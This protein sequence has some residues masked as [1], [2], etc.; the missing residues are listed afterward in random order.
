MELNSQLRNL[1]L[2]KKYT[3]EEVATSIEI[4]QA[5]LSLVEAGKRG[6][7]TNILKKLSNFY[8]TPYQLL[9]WRTLKEDDIHKNFKKEY[10]SINEDVNKLINKIIEK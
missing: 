5:Q 8:K 10:N 4:T 3:Q 9:V 6:L 2:Q 1:R 7:S